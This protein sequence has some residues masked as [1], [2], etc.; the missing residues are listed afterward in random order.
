[1]ASSR[2]TDEFNTLQKSEVFKKPLITPTVTQRLENGMKCL[3]KVMNI[4][5]SEDKAYDS[6]LNCI[7]K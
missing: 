6:E 4:E 3:K 5:Q 1:M 2:F 7:R